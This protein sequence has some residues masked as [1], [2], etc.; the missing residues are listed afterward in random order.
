MKKKLLIHSIVFSPDGVS[1]AYLYNDIALK[2][3]E[4]GFEVTVLTTTPHYNVLHNELKKQA[5]KARLGGLYYESRFN[6]IRVLHVPQKKFQSFFLRVLGFVYWHFVSLILGLTERNISLI[7]SP[8]PPLTIGLVSLIIGRLKGAKVIYNVQEIYPDFLINQGNRTF[9]PVINALKGLERLVYNQSDAVTT[10]DSVFY[11]TIVSRFTDTS[12]LHIIPNFVDT[13]I[14][15]PI[16]NGSTHID[17]QLF[18]P[19]EGVLKLMYAGNIGH[20]QDWE[21]LI[22]VARNFSDQPVEFWIIGEG[23]MKQKLQD[24]I[25]RYGLK[26]IHLI[27]YQSREH[28]PALVAY[29][30]LH[31]IF[32]SPQMDGQGFPSKVY[33]IMACAKPLLVISGK[34]TPLNNFLK[35]SDAAIL[36]EADDLSKKNSLLTA[37]IRE[38]LNDRSILS[39]LAVNGYKTILRTYT[40]EAVTSQYVNLV[41]KV[42]DR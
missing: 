30:D 26:N 17:Q 20:A 4:E 6:G 15:R 39:R 10:I 41:N 5:L 31:F 28:M 35:D 18:P 14:Y 34:N 33:T 8:S 40:K 27:P 13:E 12:K 24:D 32:M 21:P 19:K 9:K 38:V 29:A 16:I 11:Q 3:I 25:K 7:L 37:S 36:I 1:T 42:L 2:F 22:E 23:V